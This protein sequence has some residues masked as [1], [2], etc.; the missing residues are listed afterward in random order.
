LCLWD[1][2]VQAT[3]REIATAGAYLSPPRVDFR[4]TPALHG[5]WRKK[6]DNY[7]I[8]GLSFARPVGEGCETAEPL[9]SESLQVGK[10]NPRAGLV[11]SMFQRISL[12]IVT[13]ESWASSL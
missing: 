1:Q 4:D 2:G 6:K 3:K 11:E 5:A 12:Q 10:L 8:K 7:E 9:L 13:S